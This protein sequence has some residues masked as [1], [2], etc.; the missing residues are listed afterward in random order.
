M[1]RK[2]N[3]PLKSKIEVP[4]DPRSDLSPNTTADSTQNVSLEQI[5][6]PPTQPRRYF[7]PQ[8]LKELVESIKQHGILQPLLV[9]P[10][11]KGGYELVAG[12]RRYRAAKEVGLTSVPVVVR[13][14]T[15]SDAVQLALIENLLREDLNP[16]EETEG[17]LQLLAI[18]LGRAVEEVPPLLHR[19]Q[20]ELKVANNV[21]G[22]TA[23]DNEPESAN[24]VIGKT[25][26]NDEPE[27]ANNVI[28][29]SQAKKSDTANN[30]IGKTAA[31]DE[32]KS[33]NNVIGKS[34]SDGSS[35]SPNPNLIV[36][37][38]LKIIEEVFTGLG[39]MTWESFVNNRLPLLNL[40]SDILDVL[41]SGRIAYTKAKVI[42]QISEKTER[43][44]F[45]EQALVQDWS[46]SEIKKLLRAKKPQ[47]PTE[48]SDYPKRFTAVTAKLK[49]S[50]IWSDPNKRQQLETL[51]AQLEALTL[52][53]SATPE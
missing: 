38:D 3:Q 10:L 45:L 9:R 6:L 16:V 14:L 28:G 39:T 33:A 23:A 49:K 2:R 12:E 41:R 34:E 17:I 30:V 47:P 18:R 50:R 51:L 8:A 7:D 40:P 29:K 27:S 19:L 24:N 46:L 31:D 4:W 5:H 25:A 48:V 21:I 53:E 44:A 15:D 32:P 1:I 22:K 35:S 37:P 11:T 43:L 13:E 52:E 26:A 36:N 42:A 20:R